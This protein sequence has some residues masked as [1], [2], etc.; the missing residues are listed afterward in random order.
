MVPVD[1]QDSSAV[2]VELEE[3]IVAVGPSFEVVEAWAGAVDP[4]ADVVPVVLHRVIYERQEES[5]T[6]SCHCPP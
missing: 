2:N 5:G 3:E 4:Y 1:D 6:C